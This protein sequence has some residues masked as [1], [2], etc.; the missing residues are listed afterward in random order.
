MKQNPFFLHNVSSF[1]LLFVF[2]YIY[3]SL[4]LKIINGF[5]WPATIMASTFNI[6]LYFQIQ[7]VLSTV[8][9]C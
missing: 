5:S 8:E 6:G 1:I 7:K 2:I 4:L 9:A 3:L